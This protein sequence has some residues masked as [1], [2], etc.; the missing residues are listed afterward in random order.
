MADRLE[1]MMAEILVDYLEYL[2]A[3]SMVVLMAVKKVV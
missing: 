3:E 1:Y 2:T